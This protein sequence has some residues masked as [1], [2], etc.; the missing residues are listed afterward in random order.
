MRKLYVL[1]TTDYN[2]DKIY[3]IGFTK[4]SVESRIKQLQT[5]NYSEIGI[6]YIFEADN[7]IV[8][9]E[10][11]LHR[12]FMNSRVSGEWFELAPEE[13]SKIPKLCN[14]YYD[15]FKTLESNTYLQDKGATFK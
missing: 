13:V 8:S 3:K 14:Q 15:M 2:G 7:Y 11:R 9:I 1:S 10:S 4:Q 12:D 6:E 5:G